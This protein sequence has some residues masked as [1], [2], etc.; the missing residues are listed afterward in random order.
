[1]AQKNWITNGGRAQ[2]YL[3]VAQTDR[4]KGHKGINAFILERG[5]PGFEVGPKENKLRP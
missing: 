3:V 2:I 5:M 1:M 4:N